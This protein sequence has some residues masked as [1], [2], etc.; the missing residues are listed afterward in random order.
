[1]INHAA[2]TAIARPTKS[3]P[4]NFKPPRMKPRIDPLKPTTIVRT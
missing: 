2:T 3:P 4:E 1:M